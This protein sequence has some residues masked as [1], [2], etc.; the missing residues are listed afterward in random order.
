MIQSTVRERILGII[1]RPLKISE[2]VHTVSRLKTAPANA[3]IQYMNLY[4]TADFSPAIYLKADSPQWDHPI[5]VANA[6]SVT[7]IQINSSE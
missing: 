2:T 4:T 5:S 1:I 3:R 7:D 6:N